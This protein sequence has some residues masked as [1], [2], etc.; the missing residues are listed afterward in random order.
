MN[1]V[2]P[3]LPIASSFGGL[4]VEITGW[5]VL[6]GKLDELQQSIPDSSLDLMVSSRDAT[7]S[8]DWCLMNPIS[9]CIA[10]TMSALVSAMCIYAPMVGWFRLR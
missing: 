5:D 9:D 10:S 3:V 8:A 1:L 2:Y 4:S 6:V 7:S